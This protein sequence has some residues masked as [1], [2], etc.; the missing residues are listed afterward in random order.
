MP[1]DQ[2]STIEHRFE[3][4]TKVADFQD[5]ALNM[6]HMVITHNCIADQSLRKKMLQLLPDAQVLQCRRRSALSAVVN[7][8]NQHAGAY[9]YLCLDSM[10]YNQQG[11]HA[12]SIP[13]LPTPW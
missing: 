1:P 11:T 6:T 4:N 3:H 9:Y 12:C 7:A 5:R 2:S 8:D 13:A 10:S